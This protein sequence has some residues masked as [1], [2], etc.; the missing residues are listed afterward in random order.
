MV[1]TVYDLVRQNLK[2][3]IM[4]SQIFTNNHIERISTRCWVY[5]AQ[6]RGSQSVCLSFGTV[7]C[8]TIMSVTYMS[9]CERQILLG[10]YN[11]LPVNLVN[12]STPFIGSMCIVLYIY[13]QR[14]LKAKFHTNYWNSL[15]ISSF[16]IK[17]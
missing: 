10:G 4:N 17:S 16:P 7:E 15:E 3:N 9:E 14:K 5:K 13:C 8:Y 1:W 6:D 11:I 12:R 2:I